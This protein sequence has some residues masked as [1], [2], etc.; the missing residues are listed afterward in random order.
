MG[1]IRLNVSG[2][3]TARFDSHRIY[4]QRFPLVFGRSEGRFPPPLG[5][6]VRRS[7]LQS[8]DGAKC[9]GRAHHQK[10]K[11]TRQDQIHCRTTRP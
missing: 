1:L 10:R 5:L 4:D 3:E 9:S 2:E 6:K 11:S 7:L 8:A